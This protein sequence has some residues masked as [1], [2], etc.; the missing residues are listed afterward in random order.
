[1]A[2][3]KLFLQTNP[4][5]LFLLPVFFVLHGYNDNHNFVPVKDALLLTGL[6]IIYSIVLLLLFWLLYRNFYKAGLVTFLLMAFHFFFGSIHD[7]LK[8]ITGQSFVTK[9]VFILPFI[10]V[11]FITIIILIKKRKAP[12]QK[13]TYFLNT[14]LLLLILADAGWLVTKLTGKNNTSSLTALPAYK[15]CDTCAKPDIYFIV[16]DEYAGNT[17]L[18]EIFQFDNSAF[19][20]ELRSRGFHVVQ[21]SYSNYNYTPFSVASILNMSYLNLKD[22][23]RK[24]IDLKY[25]YEVIRDN[26]TLQYLTAFGYQFYNHSVFNFEGHPARTKATFL[27]DKTRLITSQTFLSRVDRDIGFNLI[28]RFKSKAALKRIT[29]FNRQN[30]NYSFD[31]TW[32]LAAQKTKHPK[33]A[34]THLMLPHYPYYYDKDGKEQPYE[35]LLEGKQVNIKAYTEY[36]Q[37][38]N[39]KLL[40][41]IDHIRTSSATPP[42]IILMGDHGFRHFEKPIKR[43]YYFMNMNAV[44]IP[45]KNYTAFTDSSS[46]VNQFRK[47]LNTQFNLELPFHKDSCIYLKD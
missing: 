15:S 17:Q 35:T 42:I 43:K 3:L 36:L 29:Y 10:T 8:N 24:E 9:Y 39:K 7:G 38:A 33:F 41:L 12:L 26:Q 31:L 2:K 32:D 44:F 28:T 1:M 45:D 25:V 11:V 19:E 23:N 21:N 5:F 37:Y 14:L 34:Y 22:T 18:K 47:I 27:P 30:N 16:A 40:S 13:T 46:T 20:N 4:V 6:Y